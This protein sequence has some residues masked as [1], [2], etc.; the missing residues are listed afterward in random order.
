MESIHYKHRND[1]TLDSDMS[2]FVPRRL[3]V[4]FSQN[5]HVLFGFFAIF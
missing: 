1:D 5:E 2:A 3:S 4:L